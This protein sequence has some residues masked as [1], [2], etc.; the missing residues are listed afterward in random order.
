[1]RYMETLRDMEISDI[2]GVLEIEEASFP[3]PWTRGMFLEELEESLCINRVVVI[4]ETVIGYSC[5]AL[6]F[7]EVHLRNIAVR[8]RYRQRG[9]ASRLL[10]DM[11]DIAVTEGAFLATLEVR[12]SSI[13]V[14]RLYE[15]FGFH[16]AGVRPK[17]YSD[18][19]EDALIMWADLRDRWSAMKVE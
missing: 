1:M 17:Y 11:I 7:D 8:E 6:V 3:T 19:R 5:F 15:R 2:D 4:E 9:I 13:H 18:T 10:E 12:R 14:Q 16:T